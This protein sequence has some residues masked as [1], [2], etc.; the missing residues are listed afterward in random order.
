MCKGPGG[1]TSPAHPWGTPSCSGPHISTQGP[2]APAAGRLQQD[3]IQLRAA[4]PCPAMCPA[5]CTHPQA[6]VAGLSPREV[7]HAWG[8]PGAPGPY[9]PGWAVGQALAARSCPVTQGSPCAPQLPA[10]REEPAPVF[11]MTIDPATQPTYNTTNNQMPV[12][13][14]TQ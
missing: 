4:L 11:T 8:C 1:T 12:V 7:P 13:K 2:S 5:P 14:P 10:P 9:A 3:W 6:H